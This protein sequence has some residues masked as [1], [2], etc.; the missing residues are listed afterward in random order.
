[1]IA[2]LKPY[3]GYKDSYVGW[4]GYVPDDWNVAPARSLFDEIIDRNHPDEEM[5]SVTIEAGVI[6]QTDFL[7][8]SQSKDGSNLDRSNYKLVLPGDIAYNKMRA[9]QGAV[10][11]SSVKGIVSP[12]YIVM[13]SREDVEPGFVHR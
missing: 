1:M 4:L 10:G 12:A 13:R 7:K 3:S 2:D 9:W 8:D 5:L 6:R 11:R